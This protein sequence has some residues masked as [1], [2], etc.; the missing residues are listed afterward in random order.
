LNT[1]IAG[2]LDGSSPQRAGVSAAAIKALTSTTTDG[3][4]WINLPVV[5]PTLVYCDMNTAGGGWM[6]CATFVDN[7][8]AYSNSYN[9]PWAA[10]MFNAQYTGIWQDNSTLG[11][12][13]FTSDYKNNV[14]NYYPMT[15]QL[16]KDS[17]ATLRNLW[18]TGAS[19]IT[20]Q[21]LST[22]W[23][24]RQWLAVGSDTSQGASGAI[25][26]GRVHYQTITNFG[27]N[28]PVFGSSGLSRILFKWGEY[29]G[30][31]DANKDRAMISYETATSTD[32]DSPKGIGC[33]TALTAD[34]RFRD[35]VPTANFA[36]SPPNT[37]TGT[38]ALT[39]W[40]R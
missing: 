23:A 38:H 26:Q 36:D 28:D 16:M 34:Y 19:Q 8:E 27:V 6:H 24:N 1:S 31:Q 14:W 33:F 15:Q 39:Y 25:A 35:V 12:Q 5:G 11:T 37:I 7:N 20:A 30:T 3:F 32:V 4:Y 40:V 2:T 21:S 17:G 29:D 22:F 13:S 18:Y 9:H 10:P